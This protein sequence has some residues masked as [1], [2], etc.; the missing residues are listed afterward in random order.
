M[1]GTFLIMGTGGSMGIPVIGCRCGVCQSS[2]PH[3]RRTRSAC[4]VKGDGKSVLIDAGPDFRSQAL[5]HHIN[6]LDAIVF[7]H[8]HQDHVGGIDDL[9]PYFFYHHGPVP[10]YMSQETAQD[11]QTRF[12]YIFKK[13]NR[14]KT[15]LP[16]LDVQLF[17][18]ER[19][20]EVIEGIPFQ[21]VTYSQLGMSVNGFKIGDLAYISDIKEYPESLFDD[22]QGT[23]TL[24][25]SALRKDENPIHFTL[26]EAVEFSKRVGA[27]KT[28]ITH[29]AH[30]LDH[31][32][33]NAELPDNVRMAYD[34]LELPWGQA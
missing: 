20:T 11:I 32:Q 24:I 4:V 5:K 30:E 18:G 21:Y 22:L 2:N 27:E 29:I 12:P 1:N 10:C 9:R 19:G 16:K 3:N 13:K 7:T 23:R 15:L 31:D 8:A 14:G 26:D 25:V 33:T 28:W 17:E 6:S 34:G